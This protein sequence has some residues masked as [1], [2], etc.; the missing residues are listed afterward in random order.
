MCIPHFFFC[1]VSLYS[2]EESHKV[3][4]SLC[5]W[6]RELRQTAIGPTWWQCQRPHV[7]IYIALSNFL[8]VLVSG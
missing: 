1:Q 4:I 6:I 3:C 5:V 7:L 2:N 8:D